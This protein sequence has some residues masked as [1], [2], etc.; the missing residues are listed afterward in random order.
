MDT[1]SEA[2]DQLFMKTDDAGT[3]RFRIHADD[4]VGSSDSRVLR[5]ELCGIMKE[6]WPNLRW[7]GDQESPVGFTIIREGQRS[8]THGAVVNM[9]APRPAATPGNDQ[10]VR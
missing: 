1:A 4:G 2:D 7:E 3:I 5:E 8:L 9:I 10:G 6:V